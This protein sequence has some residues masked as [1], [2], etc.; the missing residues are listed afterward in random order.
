MYLKIAILSALYTAIG[1]TYATAVD[2]ANHGVH[3][4]Y[5]V[6]IALIPMLG[7][8]HGVGLLCCTNAK[9]PFSKTFV[10]E[11]SL[12]YFAIYIII[13]SVLYITTITQVNLENIASKTLLFG[14]ASAFA[15]LPL[16]RAQR[17]LNLESSPGLIALVVCTT[18][19]LGMTVTTNTNILTGALAV[20]VIAIAYGIVIHN[21]QTEQTGDEVL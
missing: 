17:F 1:A 11:V 9:Q 4:L 2:H 20:W 15:W 16:W 7:S 18:L 6:A 12:I 10:A 21:Q 8:I 14:A 3:N 5:W 13:T 19:S